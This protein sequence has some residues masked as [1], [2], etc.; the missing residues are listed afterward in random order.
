MNPPDTAPQS[1][2]AGVIEGMYGAFW[3]PE[4][5]LSFIPWLKSRGYDFYIY[6]PKGDACIRR[7][8]FREFSGEYLEGLAVLADAARKQ[9]LSFGIGFTP[10]NAVSLG[11]EAPLGDFPEGETAM[12]RRVAS[13]VKDLIARVKPD[14]LAVLFDDL[15]IDSRE[16]GKAQN[17]ILK[18]ILDELPENIR[19]ITCPSFYS[20][21][22]VLEK[23]F[24][25]MPPGY[26]E[27]FARDLP[28]R[29]DIFWTG[30]RVM[31]SGYPLASLEKAREIIGRKPFIWDN[32]P[33]ND[34]RRSSGHL[35]LAPPDSRE[36]LPEGARGVAVNPMKE[37][38]LSLIPLSLIPEILKS[39]TP[40]TAGDKA[41]LLHKALL[42]E[43]SPEFADFMLRECP[44][45]S[46]RDREEFTA[47]DLESLARRVPELSGAPGITRDLRDFFRGRY[48]FDE[49]CLTG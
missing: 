47:E 28:E 24:G 3:T 2:P 26:F 25:Q 17:R 34:G 4:D 6:A 1:F 30:D 8:W 49:S 35:Y 10:L 43:T 40:V 19:L 31:S 37:H 44:D 16:A 48:I 11:G 22:P 5:R 32:Y 29:A 18:C 12:L 20:L 45:F 14:I 46:V 13:R 27:D 38:W 7:L 42:R 39:R 33:V 36:F 9:G 41:K 15:K 23:I 21:D